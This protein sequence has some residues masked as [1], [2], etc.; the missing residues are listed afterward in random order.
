[1]HAV[2]P[3]LCRIVTSETP[4]E[5]LKSMGTV[6]QVTD[7]SSYKQ[8]RYKADGHEGLLTQSYDYPHTEIKDSWISLESKAWPFTQQELAGW[9]ADRGF[10]VLKMARDEQM[11]ERINGV[12][13]YDDDNRGSPKDPASYDTVFR[14]NTRMK[15]AATARDPAS[16]ADIGI[17]LSWTPHSNVASLICEDRAT[18]KR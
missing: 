3:F 6:A 8:Y 1:M 7:L 15:A 5:T 18:S 2:S 14:G 17:S 9:L 11:G 13:D 16:S 10:Q 4:L 12:A